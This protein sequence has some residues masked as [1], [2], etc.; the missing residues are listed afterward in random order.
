MFTR[1]SHIRKYVS[2]LPS[3][4]ESLHGDKNE[5][6]ESEVIDTIEK[7]RLNEKYSIYALLLFCSDEA[8]PLKKLTQSEK[9]SML[10]VIAKANSFAELPDNASH[11]SD[12]C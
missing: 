12:T 10:S 5:Y 2:K 9:D 11:P 1:D 3:A 6:T 4:L 8:E 7:Y